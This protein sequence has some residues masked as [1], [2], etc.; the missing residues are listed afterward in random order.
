MGMA[1]H[2]ARRLA[3]VDDLRHGVEHHLVLVLARI[4]ELLRQ[5]AL[6]DQDGADARHVLQDILEVL[7]AL[8]VL[9]HQD[10][11]NL[12]LGIERPDVG[13][14]VIVLLTDAPITHRR[15][16]AVAADAGRLVQRLVLE[17]RIAAGGDRVIGLLDRADVRPD[18][19]VGA[20]IENLLGLELGLLAAV[21][22]DA[23]ERRHRRR[24]RTR[25]GDL[26]AVEHV[27]QTIAEGTD[28]VGVV[29]HLIDDGVVFRG[30]ERD[31][32]LDVGR[33]KTCQCVLARFERA[34]DA[35][36]PSQFSHS[37]LSLKHIVVILRRPAAGGP[38]RML[39][40]RTQNR[41]AISGL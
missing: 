8:G 27:L 7:D 14:V 16:R 32:R 24:D 31:G 26:A 20:E 23:R 29:L 10:D 41:F 38:R 6:A 13:A 33:R 19:A 35:V 2:D 15:G 37:V 21:R 4:A 12:A 30:G 34:D 36:E 1:D 5:I 18:D 9:D 25:F 17:P 11:E 40:R 22:R 39:P 28:V 3:G